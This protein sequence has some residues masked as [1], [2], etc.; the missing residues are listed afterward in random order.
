M[1]ELFDFVVKRLNSTGLTPQQVTEALTVEA[2]PTREIPSRLMPL[3]TLY[4]H[5]RS[6]ARLRRVEKYLRKR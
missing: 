5:L 6:D 2:L 3:V 1:D 4:R